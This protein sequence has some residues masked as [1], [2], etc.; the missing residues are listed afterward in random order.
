M[1]S[2]PMIAFSQKNEPGLSRLAPMPPTFAARWMTISGCWSAYMRAMSACLVRLYS[3]LPKVVTLAPRGSMRLTTRRPRKPWPPVTV[4]RLPVQKRSFGGFL[5]IL[6]GT[7]PQPRFQCLLARGG[8]SGEGP[9]QKAE[10]V[11]EVR[12]VDQA[13]D[14]DRHHREQDAKEDGAPVGI[15]LLPALPGTPEHDN[16]QPCERKHAEQARLDPEVEHDVVRVDE[17]LGMVGVPVRADALGKTRQARAEDRVMAEHLQRRRPELESASATEERGTADVLKLDRDP[18]K[19]R[20]DGGDQ[21][22]RDHKAGQQ[23]PAAPVR[24]R[25]PNRHRGHRQVA[26]SREAEQ[27]RRNGHQQKDAAA[28]AKLAARPMQEQARRHRD[29]R[30]KE[31]RESVGRGVD[32]DWRRLRDVIRVLAQR[33]D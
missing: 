22:A 4:T 32:D 27:H 25:Q 14:H 10:V 9:E 11:L 3:L 33:G 12:H 5:D 15:G 8:D 18:M 20:R 19:D 28:D 30:A 1:S 16:E 29:Q 7:L 13:V 6:P 17:A 23:Q 26:A 2:M 31:Q 24:K 21:T